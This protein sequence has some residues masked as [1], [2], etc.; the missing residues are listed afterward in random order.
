[1]EIPRLFKELRELV[2]SS[3]K[4]KFEELAKIHKQ[5]YDEKVDRNTKTRVTQS[6]QKRRRQVLSG[7]G[8]STTRQ[9]RMDLSK[10]P[11][12]I[13]QEI[14]QRQTREEKDMKKA[15]FDI[16]DIRYF[17]ARS[18]HKPILEKLGSKPRPGPASTDCA[19]DS[20]TGKY[21]KEKMKKGYVYTY[22]ISDDRKK[23]LLSDIEDQINPT[24]EE[25]W[26]KWIRRNAQ[27]VA[28]VIT[29]II[30]ILGGWAF[31]LSRGWW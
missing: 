17:Q 10:T 6:R 14:R 7:Q 30:T 2:K 8:G 11:E 1:M 9:E 20:A 28:V 26:W 24:K 4:I 15:F 3:E 23:Q 22:A 29:F 18:D 31:G 13:E 27:T 21:F 25:K 5:E 16:R 19:L 12:Q